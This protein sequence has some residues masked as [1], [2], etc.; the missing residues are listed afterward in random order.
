MVDDASDHK[1][2]LRSTDEHNQ[3][4]CRHFQPPF[5]DAKQDVAIN[6]GAAGSVMGHELTHGFDD[7]GRKFDGHGNLRDW[8]TPEDAKA[9]EER[10]KCISDE[11]TEEVPEYGVKT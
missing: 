5:F 2:L 4:S 6:F 8:W 3:F 11:Y 1:R 9:Y 10:A 7:E